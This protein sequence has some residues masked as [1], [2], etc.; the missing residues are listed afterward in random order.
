MAKLNLASGYSRLSIKLKAKRG[1]LR[2]SMNR[3]ATPGLR[4][5]FGWN[6]ATSGVRRRSLNR[7]KNGSK[8]L[9]RIGETVKFSAPVN[10]MSAP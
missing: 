5:D 7:L 4:R 8:R 6:K 9:V 3:L 10:V 1:E 2:T